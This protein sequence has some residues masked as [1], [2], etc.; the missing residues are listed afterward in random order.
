MYKYKET[1]VLLIVLIMVLFI[2]PKSVYNL[3]NNILGKLI[4]LVMV[5]FFTMN[6]V[7]LGLLVAL[8][9]IIV[10]KNYEVLTEGMENTTTPDTVN[11][12][13][14]VDKKLNEYSGIDITS[15][16]DSIR[17]KESK[18]IP[19]DKFV[20]SSSSENVNPFTSGMLNGNNTLT[21][22]FC[23]CAGNVF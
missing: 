7:T 2:R 12:K 19:V 11:I 14:K 10:S 18:S 6:N 5:M 20:V 15:L 3:Y 8:T 21:E 13:K 22:G 4:L 1:T 9:L 16:E 17:S 23:P